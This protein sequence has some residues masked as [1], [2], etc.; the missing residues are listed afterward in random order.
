MR[1]ARARARRA[2]PATS[3]WRRASA[4]AI[5]REVEIDL[6]RAPR[7]SDVP[8]RRSVAL[9][10]RSGR[11]LTLR[12]LRPSLVGSQAST[13]TAPEQA[14][15]AAAGVEA[16]SE[17]HLRLAEAQSAAAYQ[18]LVA[19]SLMVEQAA[20]R[21]GVNP[22]RVRQRL[23][24]RSLYGF[25]QDQSWRLPAFQF[26][27]NAVVPGFEVVARSLPPEISSLAVARWFA[28]PNADLTAGPDEHA[29]T[30]RR[31]LVEGRPPAAVAELAAAL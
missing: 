3:A 12:F 27:R 7:D 21:L 31:W 15:L 2:R 29:M 26:L 6:P 8:E 30:P 13:L 24:E 22:S 16:T 11:R 17:E 10:E 20:R 23:A 28:T 9:V 4:A 5:E 19:E 14:A 18:Q 1:N 25:K